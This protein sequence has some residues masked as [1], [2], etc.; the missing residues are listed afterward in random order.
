MALTWCYL[1][2]NTVGLLKYPHKNVFSIAKSG[3]KELPKKE[4]YL[5]KNATEPLEISKFS[6]LWYIDWLISGPG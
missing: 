2:N 3:R 4:T 1:H 6:R 5:G